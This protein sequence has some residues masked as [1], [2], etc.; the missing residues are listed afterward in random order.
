MEIVVT[1]KMDI[2]Q[3]YVFKIGATTP[4]KNLMEAYCQTVGAE[5]SQVFF[6]SLSPGKPQRIYPHYTAKELCLEDGAC[7][8]AVQ[9]IEE[10]LDALDGKSFLRKTLERWS[11][12]DGDVYVISPFVDV[13]S[14]QLLFQLPWRGKIHLCTRPKYV[15]TAIQAASGFLIGSSRGVLTESDL[16]EWNYKMTSYLNPNAEEDTEDYDRALSKSVTSYRMGRISGQWPTAEI[17]VY[18]AK[19]FHCKVFA[20]ASHDRCY[21][22]KLSC[23]ANLTECHLNVDEE[24]NLDEWIG[25]CPMDWT[26]F[27]DKYWQ[28]LSPRVHDNFAQDKMQSSRLPPLTAWWKAFHGI[29]GIAKRQKV[30]D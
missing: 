14:L 2:S 20:F 3:S 25:P 18:V 22:E 21:T 23:S 11:S 26:K 7:V 4:L 29:A 13:A 8:Q 28:V 27:L 17:I 1:V 16:L 5:P 24:T 19:T 6:L 12:Y 9:K 30:R 15:R 10:L